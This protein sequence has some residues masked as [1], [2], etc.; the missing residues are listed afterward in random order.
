MITK[1]QEVFYYPNKMGRIILLAMEEI[2]G[3]IG[4]NAVLNQMKL[5]HY[6]NDYP[7]NNLELE[8]SFDD[9]SKIQVGLEGIYG[10]RGGQG[11]ALRSG[12]AC[13]KY[14]IREFGQINGG[15][16]QAFKLLPL[17]TKLKTGA[18][19]F[20]D[21]FNTYTDQKV[22]FDEEENR[23]L[24][25]IE[26]CPLCWNRETEHTACNLAVGLLQESLYWISGGKYFYVEEISCI[27]QGA[28]TCTIAVDKHPSE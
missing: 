10:T 21:T 11:L 3:Q 1:I 14:G 15:V 12:R 23:I 22:H 18:D 24:W 19:V 2:L 17:S 20:A 7:P 26:R 9:I 8:F 5:Q 4:L 6:I 13:F 27:A 28:P 25:H 16:D